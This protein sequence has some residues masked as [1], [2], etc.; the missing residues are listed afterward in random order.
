M[1][2]LVKKVTVGKWR[3][4]CY[5]ISCNTE[6]W[7]IDPGDEVD[8]IINSFDLD[9]YDLK[10]IVNTHGHFDHI[11]AVAE[12]KER[13]KVPFFLHSRDKRL[14]T[15]GNL[16]RRMLGDTKIYK[17]PI[18]DKYLDDIPFLELNGYKILIHHTPGHTNGGIC[19]EIK[20]NLFTG[21]MLL[22]R[23]NLSSL[24]G[25]NKE[26]MELSLNFIFEKFQGFLIYPGHGDSFILDNDSVYKFK[27]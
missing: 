27:I 26:L 5:L 16:Y 18:V 9:N 17:T 3:V 4:N 6:A 15:Q 2:I 1:E 10:G 23:N 11:G 24:P 19:F 22:K 12:I 8:I 20:N 25:A 21:D 13:Y 14:A 7:I